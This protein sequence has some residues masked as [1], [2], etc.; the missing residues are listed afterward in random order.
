VSKCFIDSDI[1]STEVPRFLRGSSRKVDIAL[2]RYR[3][4]SILVGNF[5]ASGK[6]DTRFQ[7]DGKGVFFIKETID[8]PL[9]HTL[10]TGDDPRPLFISTV[11]S[12]R[13]VALPVTG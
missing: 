4:L 3:S 9:K 1:D 12:L 6:P 13:I 5:R 7:S 2:L 8:D 11:S 10:N